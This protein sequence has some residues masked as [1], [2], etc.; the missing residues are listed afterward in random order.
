VCNS[1]RAK[2][3]NH[4]LTVPITIKDIARRAR[5]SHSTVSR[6]LRDDQAV[7]G[8]TT[9]RIKRLAARM[10][11]VPSAAARSLKTSHT[12]ALAVVVTNIA[13]P[14]LGE[15]VRGI[16]EAA[17]RA[18]YSLFLA[19]SYH[20]SEREKRVLRA[21]AEHRVDGTLI[22]SS[23]VTAAH[24]A[25]LERFGVPIVLVN[26][27]IAGEFAHRIAHD[28][29]AGAEAVTRHLLALGHQRIAYLGNAGGGQANLDRCAG[30]GRALRAAGEAA[31]AAWQLTA[32]GG[33][34][35]DG[36]AGAA[37]FLSLRPRPTA[38]VCFND[39]MALGALHALKQAGMPVPQEV[40]VTGFDD[41]FVAEYADPPLT[42][43]AQ[44][45]YQLGR[46]AAEMMLGLLK[47]PAPDRPH[48]RS[49]R[50]ELVVR[51]STATPLAAQV[52]LAPAAA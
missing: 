48:E 29:I 24:L 46:D 22:C 28:D 50:G 30:Y 12:R 10:G 39:M 2:R 13:D 41:V 9:A 18:G 1:T 33:R 20:E 25:D 43:F 44:P 5:V 45:K 15:V 11:Y 14:F 51:G 52:L 3:H 19:A 34:P 40:S 37:A 42:T 16:E 17:G 7:A 6:A 27:Q 35:S 21:L 4:R 49:L 26:N 8:S 47:G 31:R 36:A 23:Q 32:S 38:L